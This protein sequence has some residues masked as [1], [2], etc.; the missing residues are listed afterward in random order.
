MPISLG[1]KYVNCYLVTA[2]AIPI[3]LTRALQIFGLK[4]LRIFNNVVDKP[5]L[6][7]LANFGH[8]KGCAG[9]LARRQKDFDALVLY[10]V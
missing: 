3:I 10:L 5:L 7:D 9:R 4:R 1:F 2:V 8:C 6:E